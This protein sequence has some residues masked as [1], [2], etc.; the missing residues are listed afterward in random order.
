MMISIRSRYETNDYFDPEIIQNENYLMISIKIW[1][2]TT[3]LQTTENDSNQEMIWNDDDWFWS[4][5]DT[6]QNDDDWFR[7]DIDTKQTDEKWF[8]YGNRHS[9][10]KQTDNDSGP[11]HDPK[12]TW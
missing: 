3:E 9:D 6:K 1:H 4:E 5:V 10:P 12:N 8:Q 7:S 11:R 2:G